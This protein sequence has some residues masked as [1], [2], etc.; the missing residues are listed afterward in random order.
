MR[1]ENA[2]ATARSASSRAWRSSALPNLP[3]HRMLYSQ[4]A[5]SASASASRSND[6]NLV[7]HTVDAIWHNGARVDHVVDYRKLRASNVEGTAEVLKLAVPLKDQA[8]SFRVDVRVP[9]HLAGCKA[10]PS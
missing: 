6:Y 4:A 1:A 10:R 3:L 9:L 8:G 7:A 2:L 5:W